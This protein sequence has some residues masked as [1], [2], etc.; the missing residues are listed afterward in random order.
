M[1]KSSGGWWRTHTNQEKSE[2]KSQPRQIQM[3]ASG[4]RGG[5]ETTEM[6]VGE[7]SR[8]VGREV[9]EEGGR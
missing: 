1:A 9:R 8:L 6:E 2:R 7:G 3:V 5:R 4:R